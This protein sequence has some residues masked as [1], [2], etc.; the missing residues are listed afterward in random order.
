MK[1]RQSLLDIDRDHS[2]KATVASYSKLV[3]LSTLLLAFPLFV[4]R[5]AYGYSDWAVL[6]LLPLAW[7][8]FSGVRKPWLST[9]QARSLLESRP[10]SPASAFSTGKLK[11]TAFSVLFV[12]VTVPILAP[13][14]AGAGLRMLLTMLVLCVTSSALVVWAPSWLR[15]YWNEP[16][17]TSRGIVFGSGLSASV[18]L[19]FVMVVDSSLSS[20]ECRSPGLWIWDWLRHIYPFGSTAEGG[21]VSG[22]LKPL[23]LLE[24]TKRKLIELLGDRAVLVQVL[25]SLSFATVTFTVAQ[26]GAATTCFAQDMA[27]KRLPDRKGEHE[28]LLDR[29]GGGMTR[30]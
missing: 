18:F 2:T 10:G 17:A 4:W 30:T 8:L 20:N 24:C 19:P 12:V 22:I 1:P 25:Y 13:M 23:L 29:D 5:S 11:A 16:F 15:R 28:S 3:V 26:A 21:W 6:L 14:A 9:I 27:R 7:M